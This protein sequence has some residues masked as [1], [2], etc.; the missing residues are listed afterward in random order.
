MSIDKKMEDA[1]NEQINA[2][3]HSAY[4]YLSMGSW[5]EEKKSERLCPLDEKPVCGRDHA[6]HEV[7]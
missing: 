7:L 3:M 5:F 4:L 1:I 6:R 2:E